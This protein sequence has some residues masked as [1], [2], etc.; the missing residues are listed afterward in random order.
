MQQW[1]QPRVQPRVQQW[2]HPRVVRWL[3]LFALELCL[4]VAPGGSSISPAASSEW[5]NAE[6]RAR[7]VRANA[8]SS[9]SVTG[10]NEATAHIQPDER[11]DGPDARRKP[12]QKRRRRELRNTQGTAPSSHVALGLCGSGG[13]G[14]GLVLPGSP[15][16]MLVG[17]DPAGLHASSDSP[18]SRTVKPGLVCHRRS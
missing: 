12:K 2:V 17:G 16:C 8:S 7:R 15:S 6:G 4:A 9:G 18:C 10:H 5:S 1:V 13:R 14:L 11:A 3:R